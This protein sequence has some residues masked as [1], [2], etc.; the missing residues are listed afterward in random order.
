[1]T[2]ARFGG[3]PVDGRGVGRAAVRAR[4][5]VLRGEVMSSAADILTRMSGP[6]T[7]ASLV[8]PP[9]SATVC[10]RTGSFHAGPAH[11]HVRVHYLTGAIELEVSTTAMDPRPVRPDDGHG[12]LGM[13][14][15]VAVSGGRLEAGG[16]PDPVLAG[17][18]TRLASVFNRVS[19]RSQE[20]VERPSGK[21]RTRLLAGS[22]QMRR[23]G[24][25]PP[26]G[27]PGPGPQHCRPSRRAVPS[28]AVEPFLV[29]RPDDLD[30]IDTQTSVTEGVTQSMGCSLFARQRWVRR[31]PAGT[32]PDPSAPAPAA[33][34]ISPS[35]CRTT[36]GD[37][38][39]RCVTRLAGWW[40][41]R[42]RVRIPSLSSPAPMRV[43]CRRRRM[44][45]RGLGR[46]DRP[47][48]RAR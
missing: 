41:R 28:G 22:F 35:S 12:L 36:G 8:R 9:P 29:R 23:R 18:G 17:L 6:L 14:E 48:V 20:L 1:M 31:T 3:V 38:M 39:R 24:L 44:R 46:L 2:I 26:P 5:G 40:S 32:S 4:A 13:R 37:S 30:C 34:A 7:S 16:L 42:S 45:R 21:E 27:Y 10:A 11:A 19:T 47:A 43:G 15:R 25:E 33:V